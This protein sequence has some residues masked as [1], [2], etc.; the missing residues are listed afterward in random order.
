M[1]RLVYHIYQFLLFDTC[2]IFLYNAGELKE[3]IDK[4][5]SRYPFGG[6]LE[7]VNRPKRKYMKVISAQVYH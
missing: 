4:E 3:H 1:A 6:K 5:R 2:K 7:H